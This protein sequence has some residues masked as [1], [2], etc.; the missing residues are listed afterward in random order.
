MA[1]IQVS[2]ERNVMLLP[3][4]DIHKHADKPLAGAH[5]IH[6]IAEVKRRSDLSFNRL[7]GANHYVIFV[8]TEGEAEFEID[9]S[10]AFRLTSQSALVIRPGM[11]YKYSSI[12][13]ETWSYW[14]IYVQG[15]HVSH[16]FDDNAAYHVYP[17][18]ETYPHCLR[19]LEECYDTLQFD[20]SYRNLVYTGQLIGQF[21]CLL[22]LYEGR[23]PSIL[24]A[25]NPVYK[26]IHYMQ[27]RLSE[28][29]SLERLSE[30]ANVSK[31]YLVKLFRRHTGYSPIDYLLRMKMQAACNELE[32][33]DRTVKEISYELGFSDPY[34]FSRL[35]S[36]M[37]SQSPT[38]Y[39]KNKRYKR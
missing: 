29:I 30:L 39:R 6:L 14:Y 13:N 23:M 36:Q 2:N 27:H 5:Y 25:D 21:I 22:T 15:A 1:R 11:S 10:S 12:A 34:Y 4:F 18:R 20:L 19:L 28:P 31:S 8:G 17:L 32:F 37:M 35:F 16:Y 9:G 33:S 26:A 7:S 24:T 38:K 3:G